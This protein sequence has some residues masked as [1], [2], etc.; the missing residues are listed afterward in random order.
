MKII[1]IK[2]DKARTGHPKV[3]GIKGGIGFRTREDVA[4]NLAEVKRILNE[5]GC[6]L[7][8]S[9]S[10]R[11]LTAHVGPGRSAT[12]FHYT[13]AAV[14]ILL[15]ST[16]SRAGWRKGKATND[17]WLGVDEYVV[18]FRPDRPKQFQ[19]WARTNKTSGS[20]EKGGVVFQVEHKTLN[21]I[22]KEPG[23]KPPGLYKVTGYFVN[24]TKIM[25]AHGLTDIPG[26]RAFYKDS[27]G[28]SEAWHFDFR[29]NIGLQRGKTTFGDVL[30]T[31]HE[32]SNLPPWQSAQRLWRGGS[33]K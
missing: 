20:V 1:K 28:A 4:P 30:R 9:G 17:N 19:V 21:G 13:S 26:R 14:D 5:L 15:P 16:L 32:P 3:A 11:R 23:G 31:M 8:S 2:S 7:A 24:L 22:R 29:K 10:S 6:V 25:W 18:E 12:S 27:T 33:F